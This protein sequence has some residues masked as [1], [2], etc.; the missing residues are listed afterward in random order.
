M[1]NDN[2]VSEAPPEAVLGLWKLQGWD[3][4]TSWWHAPTVECSVIK[5][6][7]RDALTTK[8]SYNHSHMG[9]PCAWCGQYPTMSADVVVR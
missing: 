8:R 9:V 1:T 4:R 6:P 5:S 3:T 2:E 7:D